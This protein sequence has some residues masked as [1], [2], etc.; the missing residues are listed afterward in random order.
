MKIIEWKPIEF[1]SSAYKTE[2]FKD[3][4]RDMRRHIKKV[5]S[6]IAEVDFNVGHFY[7]FVFLKNKKTGKYCYINIG[8]VRWNLGMGDWYD[9]VLIRTAK[10]D[11]DYTGGGN[12]FCKIPELLINYERLTA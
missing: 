10:H 3:F 2:Q 4:T 12:N 11:K 9:S 7:F 5:F 1:M 8:D 6:E